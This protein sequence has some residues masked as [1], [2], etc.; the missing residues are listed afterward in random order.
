MAGKRGSDDSTEAHHAVAV[1]EV[2][3]IAPEVLMVE[4][5]DPADEVPR[6]LRRAIALFFGWVVGLLV[7]YWVIGKTQSLII[8]IVIALFLSLAMEPPVNALAKHGWRRGVATGVVMLVVLAAIIAFLAA[9][10]SVVVDQT[11]SI[12]NDTPRYVRNIVRFLNDDFGLGIDAKKLIREVK[13]P[14]GAVQ[15]FGRDLTGSAPD[16]ALGIAGALLQ[17]VTTFIF[18]F[19]LTADGPKLRRTIC[20]RL[21][22]ARQEFF[23]EVWELASEKTG[24]YLYSRVLLAIAS[25]AATWLFLFLLDVPSAVAL[26]IW[27]GVISQFVP[28]IGTYIAMVLPAL[29]TIVNSPSDTLPV[30]GFLVIYN[31]FENYVLGPRIAR[32]TLKIHPAITIGAVFAGGMLFGGVGAVLSLPAA[33]VIQGLLSTYTDKHKVVQNEL[34]EEDPVVPRRARRLHVPQWVVRMRRS[35]GSKRSSG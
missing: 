34:T 4:E 10:G 29:V 11:S 32:F 13:S 33:A 35:D 30:L 23:F 19:F 3:E 21:P 22:R 1:P 18:A 25:A 14:N 12:V 26:A 27:V 17:I 15:R 8:M 31:Q 5:V 16:L 2:P 7:A 20:S 9:L 24:A 28:T 6:W